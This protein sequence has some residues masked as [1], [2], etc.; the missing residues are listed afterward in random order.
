MNDWPVLDRWFPMR[1]RWSR[2]RYAAWLLSMFVILG[3]LPY[4]AVNRWNAWR[5]VSTLDVSI[6]LDEALPFVPWLVVPYI[7]FY[8]YFPIAAWVG[9][10]D[11][12][13]EQGLVFFQRMLALTWVGLAAY[14]LLP[15]EITLRSQATGAEGVL[16]WLMD[17]L[18]GADAPYNA[19]PSLHVLQSLLT[20][21]F[22]RW[23][24]K[25]HERWNG[26]LAAA[27]WTA[28]ILLCLSTVLIKQHFIFD[29][30]IS[31]VMVGVAWPRWIA[32]A[33]NQTAH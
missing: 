12:H 18:H 32:P 20:L 30:V 1:G 23:S 33:L 28:C 2:T 13:R 31:C 8:L 17:E 6:P 16:G 27:A 15:L 25:Q 5:G 22:V 26:P 3:A 19:W 29:A 10:N 9:A 7:S 14:L 4:L 24:F 11:D 21:L